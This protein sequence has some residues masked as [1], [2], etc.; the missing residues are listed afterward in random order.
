[1]YRAVQQGFFTKALDLVPPPYIAESI[2]HVHSPLF[3]SYFTQHT[4]RLCT[5]NDMGG[6][7]CLLFNTR[8][9]R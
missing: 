5:T 8:E 7:H 4:L 9:K 6:S 2:Y 1:M 3:L